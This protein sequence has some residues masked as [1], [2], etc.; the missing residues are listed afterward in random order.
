MKSGKMT[1][2]VLEIRECCGSNWLRFVAVY[3]G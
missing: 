1:L 3:C 2:M